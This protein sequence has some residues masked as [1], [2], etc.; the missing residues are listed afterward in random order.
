[1]LAAAAVVVTASLAACGTN[2]TAGSGPNSITFWS[3]WNQGEPQQ[4]ILQQTIASFTKA[5]GI[6]VNV[7]WEGR[8]IPQKVKIANNTSNVPDLVDDT[9]EDILNAYDAG[10]YRGLDSVYG[11]TVTGTN[12]KISDVIPAKAVA[13]YRA[14]GQYVVVPYETY[15]TSLWFNDQML[16]KI[17]ATPPTS[18]SDLLATCQKAVAAGIAC[19]AD[20][21]TVPDYSSY[22][23][24]YL[25]LRY[26]GPDWLR[27]AA[28]DKTGAAFQN[29]KFLAAA[30]DLQAM[31]KGKGYM[32]SGY[33]GSKLPAGQQEWSQNKALYLLMGS[34]APH[35]TEGSASPGFSYD[36]VPFPSV[37]GGTM[38]TDTNVIGFG[39]TAKAKHPG[40]A[41]KF[42]AYFMQHGTLAKIPTKADSLSPVTSG[43]PAPSHLSSVQRQL[44]TASATDRY[45][46]G[47]QGTYPDWW[48]NVFDV[49]DNSLFFGQID[50]Q[51]FVTKLISLSKSYW[52]A[53]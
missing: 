8:E 29:P 1:M 38:A 39:I 45:L 25:T 21:G 49:A 32:L 17:G 40:L 13:P 27:T 18:F 36:S 10:I 19:V 42:I 48:T 37:P 24:S 6:K 20:D 41:A 28:A 12:E 3:T 2:G 14:K 30:K 4:V 52:S 9:G 16:K 34:W 5:T 51:Q 47:T 44:A 33:Q 22:W 7:Q 31:V 26:L 46:D 43:M 23:M 35:D 15:A 11:D 50:A 53:H